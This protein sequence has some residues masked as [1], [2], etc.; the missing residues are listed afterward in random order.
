MIIESDN[1]ELKKHLVDFEAKLVSYDAWFHPQLAL[2]DNGGAMSVQIEG[3]LNPDEII[4]KVPQRLFVATDG[5]NV[6]LKGNDFMIDP[7]P[8]KLTEEQ[9]EVGK[10]MIDIYNITDKATL[11]RGE[12]PWILY[13][14]SPDL[15]DKLTHARTPNKFIQE[16]QTY[17]HSLSGAKDDDDFTC[18]SFLQTRVLGQKSEET[19]AKQQVMM[20]IIDYLNHDG[21]GCPFIMRKTE[22]NGNFMDIQNR[23]PYYDR[24]ECCVSYGT[25]DTLDT[26]LSYGFPDVS[27]PFVRSIPVDYE[28]EGYG[29]MRI[30]AMLGAKNDANLPKEIFD[31]RRF[32][33]V[34]AKKQDGS[35]S[36][37]HII[38][39]VG[40][41]PHAMRRVLQVMIRSF[42]GKEASREVVIDNVYAAEDKIIK[43]N[44]A[45]YEAMLKSIK[46]IPA[47]AKLKAPIEFIANVQLN[48]LYKYMYDF[49]FFT[50][51]NKMQTPVPA[52]APAP[53]AAE[54]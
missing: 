48:K 34:P 39:P 11:H 50:P 19:H 14:D 49:N 6:S 33:P 53:A 42:I 28:V 20:P 18:W 15:L 2:M 25:Y 31:L 52:Q 9:I 4:M 5:L 8:D 13:K 41:S 54:A 27:A 12:C 21:E 47:D 36:V 44:I 3:P 24:R 23:Q 38:I 16:K 32:M 17:L 37:S 10:R 51:A 7:D 29:T 30:S 26:F 46:T 40:K 45:F 22:N 35:L 1:K 43:D